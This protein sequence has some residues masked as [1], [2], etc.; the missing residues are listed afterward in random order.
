MHEYVRRGSKV[1]YQVRDH[2]R[3]LLEKHIKK[4]FFDVRYGESVERMSVEDLERGKQW[5]SDTFYLIRVANF[6]SNGLWNRCENDSLPSIKWVLGLA[7]AAVLRHGVHGIVIDP[8]NE[9]DHQRPV[10]Q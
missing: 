9:L 3:K 4:P 2:A 5:L 7:K 1:R 8:Y 10:S 6:V